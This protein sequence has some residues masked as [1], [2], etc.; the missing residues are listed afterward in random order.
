[1]KHR[2]Q[3]SVL[4]TGLALF[5]MFFGAG[6]VVFPLAV[7]RMAGDQNIFAISGL[8]LTAVTVPFFGLISMMLYQGNFHTFFGRTGKIGGIFLP[9][10]IMSLIGPFVGIPR[11]IALSYATVKLYVPFINRFAFSLLACIILYAFTIRKSR[12]LDLLGYVLSPL[13]LLSLSI[14]II[15]GFIGHPAAHVVTEKPLTLFLF[16]LQEGYKTLD[17]FAAFFFATVVFLSLQRQVGVLE[18]DGY[19][20]LSWFMVKASCISAVLIGLVYVGFSFVAS[21]Y[22]GQ[23]GV[24]GTDEFLGVLASHIL[25]AG[26]GFVGNAAV[27]LACL[28]TAI[29]L[30]AIFADYVQKELVLGRIDYQYSLLITLVITFAMANLGFEKLMQLMLPAWFIFYPA[31]IVL[32]VLNIAYKLYGFKPVK[33]PVAITLILSTFHYYWFGA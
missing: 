24:A 18:G 25:G 1:M 5:S 26:A 19:K 11:C 12:I 20:F 21:Y 29:T 22:T 10:L 33:V 8:L 6:N 17:L 3:S 27:A 4:S 32:S 30:C 9:V 23:V 7:G 15:K 14:L 2:M 13:L 31:L 28:T 16:G